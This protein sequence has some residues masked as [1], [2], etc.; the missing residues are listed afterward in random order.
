[1]RIKLRCPHCGDW[2]TL[3]LGVEN[4]ET[5]RRES[6]EQA[7]EADADEEPARPRTRVSRAS[8]IGTVTVVA[9]AVIVIWAVAALRSDRGAEVGAPGEVS[10]RPAAVAVET[11]REG[12]AESGGSETTR[13]S[14]AESGGPE[15]EPSVTQLPAAEPPG[16]QSAPPDDEVSHVG[17]E[18]AAEE[19]APAAGSG[20]A[21]GEAR[22]IG[23]D[24]G[25]VPPAEGLDGG[26]A[27]GLARAPRPGTGEVPSAQAEPP[28]GRAV[29]A[30]DREI[31]ELEI[32]ALSR[33]WVHVEADGVVVADATL[34]AG[35]RRTWR[36]DGFFDLS[37]GAGNAVRL[38][39]NGK[40][41]GPAGSDARVV[42]ELRVTRDGVRGH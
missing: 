24:E 32:E 2:F 41:L 35:E 14:P 26:A 10:A 31:L 23:A 42:E 8:L 33:C 36:A 37:V 13:G 27:G 12:P 18:E 11:E 40:D 9:A 3:N 38:S 17:G 19:E 1:M 15:T 39:L 6:D 22:S 29:T 28:E 30:P 5:E 7:E 20:D 21:S 34:E 16:G 25:S 4:G